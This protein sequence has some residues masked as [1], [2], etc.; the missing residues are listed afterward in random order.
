[1]NQ[2]NIVLIDFFN[3]CGLECKTLKDLS[4]K[5]IPREV[6]LDTTL[7]NSLYDSIS[8]LKNIYST[9]KTT[10]LQSSAETNQKWPL[11]NLVRQILKLNKF[12]LIPLRMSD[13]YT[14][15][16]KKKYKRYFFIKEMIN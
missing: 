3:K 10:C 7:Y 12:N 6:L 11:L 1:M 8:E 5:Q 4:G 15:D 16:G 9:T 2:K 13:G 14:K